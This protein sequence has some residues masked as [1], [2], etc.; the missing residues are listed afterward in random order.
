MAVPKNFNHDYVDHDGLT[1]GRTLG[2]LLMEIIT[3]IAVYGEDSI[4]I[5]D[6]GYNN[7]QA[8]VVQDKEFEMEEDDGNQSN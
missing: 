2:E 6:A 4:V 1:G 5:F 3:L 8:F 7:V